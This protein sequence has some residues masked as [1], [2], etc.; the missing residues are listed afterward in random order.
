MRGGI[1]RALI[2]QENVKDLAE[3]P[4]N[5]KNALEIIPVKWIDQVLELTLERMPEPLLDTEPAGDAVVAAPAAA[6]TDE[7]SAVT[8]LPH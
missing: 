3:I 2:P 5:I 1:R 8:A 7:G 4:D 6:G